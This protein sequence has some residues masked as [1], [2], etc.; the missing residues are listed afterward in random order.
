MKIYGT[1]HAFLVEQLAEDED[2]GSFL[3]AVMEEYQI[4][5]NLDIIQLALQYI[6][7]AQGGISEL[8]KKNRY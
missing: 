7:E 6:V 4:H 3:D 2:V 1:W 8:T 5:H